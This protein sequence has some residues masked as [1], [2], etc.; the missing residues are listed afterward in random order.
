[1]STFDP[2]Q[3]LK[4]EADRLG[5][6]FGKRYLPTTPWAPGILVKRDVFPDGMGN[7]ISAFTAERVLPA[8]DPTWTARSYVLGSDSATCTPAS[9]EVPSS[10]TLRT[11]KVY[12]TALRSVDICHRDLAITWNTARQLEAYYEK[13]G[14]NTAYAWR[15]RTRA[16]VYDVTE[17]LVA[18]GSSDVSES[19]SAMP[20]LYGGKLTNSLLEQY[21]L[22]LCRTGAGMV[23]GTPMMDGVPMFPLVIGPEASRALLRESEYRTD[24]RENNAMV[25]ELLK[26]LGVKLNLLGF[27]HVVDLFPRRWDVVNGAW[28]ERKPWAGT[29]A[30]YGTKQIANSDYANAEY[31]DAVIN[32]GAATTQLIPKMSASPGGNTKVV[33]VDFTGKWDYLVI[34]DKDT[35]PK[36]EI[37]FFQADLACAALPDR[38]DHTIIL[39]FKRCQ[40]ATLATCA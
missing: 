12:Y 1:M 20:V 38:P 36:G 8:S 39:R 9:V 27:M 31:E 17:R 26:P 29:A 35:N 2:V 13:L 6:Y 25:P 30:T 7:E 28:V 18:I 23:A 34:P 10:H 14:E 32:P 21:H 5:P 15:E 22:E 33:P 4:T 3:F 11:Y 24:I 19:S 40:S 37:G 16:D